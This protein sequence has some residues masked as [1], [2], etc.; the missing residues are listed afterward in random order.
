MFSLSVPLTVRPL[1]FPLLPQQRMRFGSALALLLLASAAL[2]AAGLPQAG[3]WHRQN[4]RLRALHAT[5]KVL[6]GVRPL[7]LANGTAYFPEASRP[8]RQFPSGVVEAHIQQPVDHYSPRDTSEYSQRF[9]YRSVEW[10][11][12]GKQPIVFLCVGGEGPPLDYTVLTDSVH[13]SEMVEL[14]V[15]IG[16]LMVAIEHRGYGT[17]ALF[18]N[19]SVGNMQHLNSEQALGDIASLVEYVNTWMNLNRRNVRWVTFGGSYPGM[20]A[21][22]A[23][24]KYP[25]LIHASIASSAPINA[26]VQMEGYNVHVGF[27]TTIASIGGSQACLKAIRDGHLTLAKYIVSDPYTPA[28]DFQICDVLDVRDMDSVASWAG[29]GVIDI[30][31]QSNDPSCTEDY[32]NIGKI[33]A[34][35]LDP[36]LGAT[37]YDRLV[38]IARAQLTQSAAL[39]K[40]V[41]KGL[42]GVG[43]REGAPCRDIKYQTM[44]DYLQ[45]E[46]NDNGDRVWTYQTCFEYGFYQTCVSDACPFVRGYNTLGHQ[47]ALCDTLFGVKPE[48]IARNVASTNRVFGGLLPRVGRI[49]YVNGEVDPWREL[50]LTETLSNDQPVLEVP[51]ASH[52]FWTHITKPTDSSAVVAARNWIKSK[53]KE[54]L[55]VPPV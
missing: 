44:V 1:H 8:A 55:A 16:A 41:G 35:M 29:N 47:I 14:A 53:V 43:V 45:N 5:P 25:H 24:V 2:L 7:P 3:F 4:S 6:R 37:P 23:R 36:A 21:S 38:S 12:K 19:L 20:M 10:E 49:A 51:G 32:C 34:G 15:S 11:A 30:P 27:A 40:S 42:M 18:D 22:F 48:P 46:S 26:S 31:A 13:C 50:S 17:S 54:W 33:C 9:F 39:S 52:H 28:N